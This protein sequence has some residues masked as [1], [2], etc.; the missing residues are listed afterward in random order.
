MQNTCLSQI[1]PSAIAF[2][3]GRRLVACTLL[4]LFG[5]LAVW[6][7]GTTLAHAASEDTRFDA[8]GNFNPIVPGYFADPTIQKF[9]DL[10]Y[11]YATTDGNGGGR[12]PSQVWVSKDFVNWTLVPMH[13]P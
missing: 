9:G 6:G 3:M 2:Q 1:Q 5:M 8:P 13:W 7:S 4:C 10:Y 12:G 11:L